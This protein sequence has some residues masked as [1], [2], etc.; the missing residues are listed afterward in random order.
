MCAHYESV[1][2]K[3]R[4]KQHFGIDLPNE[5]ARHDVWPGYLSTFMPTDNHPGGIGEAGLPPIAPA[6]ANALASLTGKRLHSLPFAN[7]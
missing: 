3:A 4:L 5:L 2:N 7:V 6:V 1:H